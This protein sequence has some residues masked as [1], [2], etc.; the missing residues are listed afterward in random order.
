[1]AARNAHAGSPPGNAPAWAFFQAQILSYQRTALW[2]VMSAKT[3]ATRQ[4]RLTTLIAD[5]AEGYW[6]QSDCVAGINL[7]KGSSQAP[8]YQV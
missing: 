7:V 6:N 5:S 1:M 2:W 3:D 4:R 8:I